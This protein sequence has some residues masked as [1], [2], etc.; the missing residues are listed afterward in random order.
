MSK[1][2]RNYSNFKF[3]AR[4]NLKELGISRERL[5]ELQNGCMAGKYTP[6]MLHEVCAGFEFLEPWIILSVTKGWSYDFI[7]I[8]WELR[9]LERPPVERSDF[10]GYRRR[11]YYNLDN[12]LKEERS[13]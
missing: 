8:K 12:L 10:Y 11:F 9:E 4:P 5:K 6:E 1:K 3:P 13:T 2:K 7:I